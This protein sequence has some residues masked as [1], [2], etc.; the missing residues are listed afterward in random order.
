[1]KIVKG[2]HP[3]NYSRIS[4]EMISSKLAVV[5]HEFRKVKSDRAKKNQRQKL[6]CVYMC[7]F[8]VTIPEK[9]M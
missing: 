4:N 2:N 1:M 3:M 5:P 8:L 6:F 7:Q 9:Q